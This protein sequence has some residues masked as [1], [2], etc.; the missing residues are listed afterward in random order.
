LF[1]SHGA[2]LF[3]ELN[4]SNKQTKEK[5]NCNG[6]SRAWDTLGVS[7]ASD[8]QWHGL[9]HW[10]GQTSKMVLHCHYVKSLS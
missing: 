4:S 10:L 6:Q 8:Y 5:P 2:G 7:T 3:L 9:T 1:L